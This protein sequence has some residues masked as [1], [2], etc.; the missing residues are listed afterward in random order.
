MGSKKILLFVNSYSRKTCLTFTTS[1]LIHGFSNKTLAHY[2]ICDAYFRMKWQ[3][4]LCSNTEKLSKYGL[5]NVSRNSFRALLT[6]D[7]LH[8]SPFLKQAKLKVNFFRTCRAEPG[9]FTRIT[10]YKIMHTILKWKKTTGW[11]TYIIYSIGVE[12]R[13]IWIFRITA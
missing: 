11:H 3:T 10:C 7:L 4:I 8:F 12:I 1:S 6:D 5:L 13:K 2:S 9:G